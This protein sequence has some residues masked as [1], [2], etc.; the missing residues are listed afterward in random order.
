MLTALI[1]CATISY[2]FF[3]ANKLAEKALKLSESKLA[4]EEKKLTI[5]TDKVTTTQN[6]PIKRGEPM[7]EVLVLSALKH[8]EK[9]A[10]EDEIKRYYELYE[11]YGDWDK[12]LQFAMPDAIRVA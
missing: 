8:S 12:V 2:G 3:L 6:I 11:E 7:P 10:Q 9:W 4:L 5:E 1:V